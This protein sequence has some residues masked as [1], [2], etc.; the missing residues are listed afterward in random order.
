MKKLILFFCLIS[1]AL[2]AEWREHA[3][4]FQE[5]AR[6]SGFKPPAEFFVFLDHAEGI[7]AVEHGAMYRFITHPI[8]FLEE[9]GIGITALLI[10]L[11]GFLLN[12]TP[13]I[14]PMIPVNIAI[15][16]DYTLKP[17][18]AFGTHARGFILGGIYGLGIATVYGLLGL[19][20]VS[21]SRALGS[22]NSNPWFNAAI[23]AVF[24]LMAL[25]MFGVFNIDFS[26]FSAGQNLRFQ[27]RY[28]MSFVMGGIAALL[29]G[30]CIAPV[31][32]SVLLLAG[33]LYAAGNSAGIFLPFLLGVGMALPWPF[34]GAGIALLPK[35][36]KW[37]NTV[38]YIFGT[39]ILMIALYYVRVAFSLTQRHT[40]TYDPALLATEFAGA[41]ADQQPVFLEFTADWCT[42]CK[43]MEK[44]TFSDGA[45]KKRLANYRVIKI[46]ATDF[47]N[48]EVSAILD[49]FDVKGLPTYS[50]LK[51]K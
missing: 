37:M 12:F 32:L 1:A 33:T 13:C 19:I 39:V 46:D 50:V 5:T 40:A 15:I 27:S 11:G 29:A 9:S 30:A 45:V 24:V 10:L 17:G 6:D 41:L 14:L 21:G 42:N 3:D 31:V 28:I 7:P 25:A 35:P 18:G 43:A 26:R 38:K 23:A 47:H 34:A 2:F 8:S 48:P 4:K 44:H 20:A 16:G 22:L 36:G 49:Y 51:V